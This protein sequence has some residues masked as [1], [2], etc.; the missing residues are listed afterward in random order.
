MKM[1]DEEALR[2]VVGVGLGYCRLLSSDRE[3]MS[4]CGITQDGPT[5]NFAHHY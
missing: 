5:G 4:P 3:M 2:G 1:H